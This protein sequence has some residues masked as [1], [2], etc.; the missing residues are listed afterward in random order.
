MFINKLLGFDVF[1]FPDLEQLIPCS[2]FRAQL[3]LTLGFCIS[4]P[5]VSSN[6]RKYTE[7]SYIRVKQLISKEISRAEHEYMNIHPQTPPPP[8]PHHHHHHHQ[9]KR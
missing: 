4:R 6:Y 5:L 1:R 9:L 3:A 8:T 7:Y 2:D